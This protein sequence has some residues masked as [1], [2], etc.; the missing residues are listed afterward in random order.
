MRYYVM[1]DDGTFDSTKIRC[2]DSYVTYQPA[3]LLMVVSGP[4][5]WMER[6]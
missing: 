1:T 5:T 4:F 3:Y 6:R 2:I